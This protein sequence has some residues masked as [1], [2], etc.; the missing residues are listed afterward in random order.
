MRHSAG[1]SSASSSLLSLV[2]NA[3][4]T[5]NFFTVSDGFAVV[6]FIWTGWKQKTWSTV[7]NSIRSIAFVSL[8]YLRRSN[9]SL[10]KCHRDF[11]YDWWRRTNYIIRAYKRINSENTWFDFV[12][13]EISFN[14][15]HKRS[16]HI[17]GIWMNCYAQ[18]MST[19]FE[20]QTKSTFR[21][22]V[23][24]I[25]TT[26]VYVGAIVAVSFGIVAATANA[27]VP[28]FTFHRWA[29]VEF[30][31]LALV[32]WTIFGLAIGRW[33]MGRRCWRWRCGWPRSGP[34][35]RHDRFRS[36]G[37]WIIWTTGKIKNLIWMACVSCVV[38]TKCI[39]FVPNP[40]QAIAHWHSAF[41]L[42]WIQQSSVYIIFTSIL[43]HFGFCECQ[44]HKCASSTDWHIEMNAPVL[45][46]FRTV[47]RIALMLTCQHVSFI[48][49]IPFRLR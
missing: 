45:P 9:W 27:V 11:R 20:F 4:A 44:Q 29:R 47:S 10:A 42:L 36:P 13:T 5:V 3:L 40:L 12:W 46:S 49:G 33:W 48:F 35:S 26:L 25:S 6:S 38:W 23:V 34:R 39:V 41:E 8:N 17:E 18:N 24:T 31:Q 32:P 22:E 43:F 28:R 15:R 1:I 19:I 14:K 16:A 37:A 7:S 30:G 21:H 2:L